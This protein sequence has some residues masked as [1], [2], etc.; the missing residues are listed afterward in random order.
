MPPKKRLYS[1]EYLKYGFTSLE[2]NGKQQP[3]CVICLKVL[4]ESAMK[5]SFLK[6]HLEKNHPDKTKKDI[7]YFQRLELSTKRARLEI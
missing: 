2:R 4:A 7:S 6:R 5:P 1:S 3:Q